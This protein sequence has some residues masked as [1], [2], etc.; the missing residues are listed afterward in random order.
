MIAAATS[1]VAFRFHCIWRAYT[2]SRQK[3]HSTYICVQTQKPL[4]KWHTHRA[5][6][7]A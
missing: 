1:K 5:G 3:W 7:H 4:P 6:G 2:D